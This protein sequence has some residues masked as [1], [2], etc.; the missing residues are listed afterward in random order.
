MFVRF[1]L[2]E[3]RVASM[4]EDVANTTRS[5]VRAV[6]GKVDKSVPPAMITVRL[7]LSGSRMSVEI[8]DE[9]A[10]P[11]LAVPPELPHSSSGVEALGGGQLIWSDLPLPS[12]MDATVVPLPRRGTTKA[13][14]VRP[15]EEENQTDLDDDVMKRILNA[16]KREPGQPG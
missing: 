14:A 3:W 5:L 9:R 1:T 2:T 8:E 4:I 6:V 10:S 12:G 13:A 16:L 11:R 7:R 15:P